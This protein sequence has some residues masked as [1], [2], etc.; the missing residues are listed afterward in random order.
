MYDLVIKAAAAALS[1]NPNINSSLLGTRIKH[2]M[3]VLR[4][5][6]EAPGPEV[7]YF[8]GQAPPDV[9]AASCNALHG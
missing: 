5:S 2:K 3:H 6:S 9:K 1:K 8:A 4:E 7:T